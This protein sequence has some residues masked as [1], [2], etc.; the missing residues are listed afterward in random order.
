MQKKLYRSTT[1]RKLAGVCAGVANY[2]NIDPTVVRI[3][4]AVLGLV[5]FFGIAAYL[6][7]AIIIPEE[8][9]GFIEGQK[10]NEA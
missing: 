2:L 1:D 5:G 4:W 6:I 10:I 9:S 3:I 7:C 8:P